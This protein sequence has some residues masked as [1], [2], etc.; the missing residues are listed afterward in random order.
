MAISSKDF[1]KHQDKIGERADDSF[2]LLGWGDEEYNK[3]LGTLFCK[4][5]GSDHWKVGRGE[6]LTVIK[7]ITCGWEASVHEG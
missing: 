7:C 3:K 1:Y 6:Y 2:S 5:C 4:D